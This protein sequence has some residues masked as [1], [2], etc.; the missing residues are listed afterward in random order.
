MRKAAHGL[1]SRRR[2]LKRG[3]TSHHPSISS[4][5]S[6]APGREST[7]AL[8]KDEVESQQSQQRSAQGSK[9]C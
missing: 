3:I 2:E 5:S 4:C 8:E 1:V 6:S 9:E 7:A